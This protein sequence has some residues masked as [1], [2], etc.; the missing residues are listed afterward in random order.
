MAEPRRGGGEVSVGAPGEPDDAL[1]AGRGQLNADRARRAR[2]L[3]GDERDAEAG[4]DEALDRC[5]VAARRPL[6]G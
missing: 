5:Q 2:Q 1:G 6:A 4:A 3:L